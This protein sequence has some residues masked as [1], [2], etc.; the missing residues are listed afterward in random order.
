[1]ARID[2]IL[3]YIDKS[4]D[5]DIASE[6][7]VEVNKLL[8]AQSYGL[9]F[10][11][12]DREFFEVWN[13]TPAKGDMVRLINFS[14]EE[15][16]SSW[17]LSDELYYVIAKKRGML[18]LIPN[19]KVHIV[20]GV[21][22]APEAHPTPLQNG[23]QTVLDIGMDNDSNVDNTN[24]RGASGGSI[25]E[26]IGHESFEVINVPS[27]GAVTIL[28]SDDTRYVYGL[29]KVNNIVGVKEKKERENEDE[30]AGRAGERVNT[31]LAPEH[32]VITAENYSALDMLRYTHAGKIDCI[33]I[34]PPYNTGA[35]DWKYNDDYVD[36]NDQFRHSKW[37]DFMERRLL[38]AKELLSPEDSVLILTI[39]EYEF[40]AIGLLL[41]SVFADSIVEMVTTIIN[42]SGNERN[43]S[44]RRVNEYVYFVRIGNSRPA[45]K[46]VEV[47]RKNNKV[48]WESLRFHNIKSSRFGSKLPNQFYP[49]YL[50]EKTH[51][52]VGR[53]EPIWID[54]KREDYVIPEGVIDVWPIREDGTEM[55]WTL[56]DT[57]FDKMMEKGYVKIGT[58]DISKKQKAIIKYLT[59]GV[60]KAIEDG[61][62]V[63]EEQENGSFEYVH[64]TKKV[65]ES[66]VLNHPK[67]IANTGGSGL[68]ANIVGDRRFPYPKS[69]YYIEDLMG[70]FVR[71]KKDAIILDFFAGSGTTAHAVMRL[72]QEDNGNRK[73][74]SVTVN[75]LS[76]KEEKGFNKKG[77]LPRDKDW[78]DIGIADYVTFPRLKAAVTG[79][80][81]KSNYI[82]PI[83]GDYKYNRQAKMSDGIEAN[84]THYE[85]T[86]NKKDLVE[87]NYIY[88]EIAPLL[89]MKSG[90]LGDV[91][92]KETIDTRGYQV[93]K[94]HGVIA[95]VKCVEEFAEAI[96]KQIQENNES[97]FTHV[98]VLTNDNLQYQTIAKRFPELKVEKLYETYI[99]AI[100]R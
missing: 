6:L 39:D 15:N 78:Q 20:Y 45:K 82:E 70:L 87:N 60:V 72:N 71:D 98:F 77:I 54:K 92:D 25:K 12:K 67:Y 56:K 4:V 42:N 84:V 90:Q 18:S 17:E 68:I 64:K 37:L 88:D 24:A 26:D 55:I 21:Q 50:D 73:S 43:N 93:T 65:I 53:G 32:V 31:E 16:K 51:E 40:K 58:V 8:K 3:A 75:S 52:Y 96:D 34:D 28:P 11:R 49:I 57:T 99:D 91:T 14:G 86:Y 9:V 85:L 74:I 83:K 36:A 10:E 97:I 19:D 95:D 94:T 100:G 44:F 80:T 30:S 62:V 7:R 38:L 33:F 13:K 59:K 23:V 27:G 79:K 35:K 81:A 66:T 2:E 61:D 89:M 69:L 29:K 63:L 41:E 48:L 1:M 47:D 46:I 5:A 76:E 22:K